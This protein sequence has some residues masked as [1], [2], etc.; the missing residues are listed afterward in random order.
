VKA[1]SVSQYPRS[2]GDPETERLGYAGAKVMGYSIRNNQ[3]RY[4]IWMKNS[5]RSTT[6]FS[7]DAVMGEELYDYSVDPLEKKNVVHDKN[8]SSTSIELKSK[9]LDYFKSQEEK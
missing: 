7:A 4:T 1:F 9:M 3:Y 2:G 5:F 6:A 8:Y